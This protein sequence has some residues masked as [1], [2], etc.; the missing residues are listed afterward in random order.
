MAASQEK[1]SAALF[2]IVNRVQLSWT[3]EKWPKGIKK[4]S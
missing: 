4:K 2:K 1:S 3:F